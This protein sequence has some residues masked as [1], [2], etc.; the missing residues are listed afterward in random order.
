LELRE[1]ADFVALFGRRD[2][3]FEPGTQYKYANYGFILL[4]R[5]IEAVCG[6]PYDDYVQAN[7]FNAAGMDATGALPEDVHVAGRAVGYMDSAAGLVRNDER[8]PYRGSPAGGG[9]T[10]VGDL[11]RFAR[12][13]VGGKLLGADAMALI[14][15]GGV[16]SS[17]GVRWYSA[18]FQE[19]QQGG[20]RRIGHNG[21]APGM[22]GDLM[23]H[24]ASG[25]MVA[26][27][28]NFDPPQ[29][30]FMAG[31]VSLRLPS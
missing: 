17:P 3:E 11:V 14:G 7:V 8:L 1:P 12:A 26:A 9:Y 21:G 31:F 2:P 6:Q 27:L 23:I 24:P 29:A 5:I 28:S 4:G 15:A 10:T 22:N 19:T 13:L 30:N 20:V 16:E 25:Y 18:G